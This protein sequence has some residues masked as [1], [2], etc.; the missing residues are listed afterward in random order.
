MTRYPLSLDP[1][2]LAA[3]SVPLGTS[4][5]LG[6]CM[7]ARGKQELWLRRK[8]EL[9]ETLRERAVIQSVE[10]SNRIEGVTVPAH[11]LRP[12]VMAKAKP[13]D[14]PEEELAGYRRALE[15]VFT[16]RGLISPTPQIVQKLHALAQGGTTSDAGHWKRL[17]N[18]IVEFG[19]NGA[20]RLRFRPTP[21]RETPGAV[22][23]LCRSYAVATKEARIPGVILASTFV[24]D[25]LCIH[26]FRDGNG[27]VSR[28]VT[29]LLLLGEGFPVVRYVSLERLVEERKD[30]YYRVLAECST[31]W[32]EGGNEILPWW[33][34][35]LGVLRAACKEL[36][37]QVESVAG[38]ASKGD[39]VRQ[40]VFDQV[41]EF[42]VG[43]VRA[44]C[45]SVST[46]L[47]RKVL[48]DLK[49]AGAVGLTG[50]GRGARWVSLGQ[51]ERRQPPSTRLFESTDPSL[52]DE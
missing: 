26:P 14:R 20:P 51:S 32:H 2:R 6:D 52:G 19:P 49:R 4:W 27:R 34:F 30:E 18:E 36:E 43:D 9:L 44:L 3:V 21:A 5:L 38:R 10:S 50:R 1:D 12:L 15:W 28:L 17:N 23:Q 8:P 22:A 24:F 25:L 41:G 13:L 48:Q 37:A 35:F 46:P 11:R 16:R 29:T 39:L 31:G 7:E 33:N 45:P 47:V 40:A 42:T